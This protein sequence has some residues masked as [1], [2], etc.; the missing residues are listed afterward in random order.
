[1]SRNS[2]GEIIIIDR[3]GNKRSFE[4]ESTVFSSIDESMKD[5]YF[6]VYAPLE[7]ADQKDKNEKL[8]KL[9]KGISKI[10]REMEA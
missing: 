4:E 1:M 7:Y 10:L 9:K 3:S 2:E 5:M 6:E 8:K